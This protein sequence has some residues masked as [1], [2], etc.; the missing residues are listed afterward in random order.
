MLSVFVPGRLTNPLNGSFGTWFKHARI[1]RGWR[2]RTAQA[3]WA[4]KY[5]HGRWA[6]NPMAP[7]RI[8]FTAHVG[9]TWDDD[10]LPAAIKPCRDA[11]QG[12]V[13][14]TDAPGGGHTFCY[15]QVTDRANRGVQI[16][17]EEA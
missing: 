13:I 11:L 10:N 5:A 14:H 3:F 6:L 1:A 7:K 9:A 8:T 16:T 15:R 2:E 4:E 12:I 17:V